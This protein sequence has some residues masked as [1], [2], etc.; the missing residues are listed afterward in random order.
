MIAVVDYGAGNLRSVEFA[1]EAE[2]IPY[3]RVA[4]PEALAAVRGILLPGVG[5]AG[6]AMRELRR[7]GLLKPLRRTR[8]P[9]L[10][11]C[12]G[13]QLLTESSD[14]GGERVECLGRIPGRTR[15]FGTADDPVGT[16]P[17]LPQVGWNEVHL[18]PDPLL[19]GL[20][21]RA[22]FYFLHSHRV[23]CGAGHVIGESRHGEPFPAVVRSRSLWGVQFHPEKSGHAGRR[24]LRNFRRVCE[25]G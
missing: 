20:G 12:L 25:E 8:R 4:V 16:P 15:R 23:E 9:L 24:V 1:L 5:A 17:R 18:S 3:R 2:G 10:G 19:E 7:R 6:W 13:M 22:W 14:E 11:V 21:D